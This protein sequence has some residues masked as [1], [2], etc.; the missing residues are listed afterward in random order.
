MESHISCHYCYGSREWRIINHNYWCCKI[1]ITL[2]SSLSWGC[3]SRFFREH[4]LNHRPVNLIHHAE[5]MKLLWLLVQRDVSG[6]LSKL[7]EEIHS[8]IFF[9]WVYVWEWSKALLMFK[10]V[11]NLNFLLHRVTSC[12]K[13]L[14]AEVRD[15]SLHPYAWFIPNY[16]CNEV[17]MHSMKT[18]LN[19][20]SL[21][22]SLKDAIWKQFL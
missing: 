1:D 13:S 8:P 4:F 12:C 19:F 10:T 14:F 21:D 9:Y 18:N 6:L 22:H 17:I 2:R 7:I 5:W 15:K 16:L 11:E 20:F 3:V